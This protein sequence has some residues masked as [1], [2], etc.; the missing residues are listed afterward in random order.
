VK[1][2][3]RPEAN[4]TG[5][6]AISFDLVA[7]RLELLKEIVPRLSRLAFVTRTGGDLVDLERMGNGVNHAADVLG[8]SWQVFYLGSPEDVDKAFAGFAAEG[9]DAAYIPPGP[10]TYA[11]R[12][13][14]GDAARQYRIPT[15]ADYDIY[16]KSGALLSY[17]VEESAVFIRAAEYIDRILRGATPADLPVE[18]PTKFRLMINLRTA[19]ALGLTIPESLLARA[20]EVIE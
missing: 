3:A 9:I 14:I 10:F 11:N 16:A 15:V 17:G 1:N 20:D 5:V 8:F 12:D 4:V 13:Q 19:K 6:S 2:L 7:K 18:Q